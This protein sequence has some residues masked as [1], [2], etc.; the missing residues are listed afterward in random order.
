MQESS[1]ADRK[2]GE[3]RLTRGKQPRLLTGSRGAVLISTHPMGTSNDLGQGAGHHGVGETT[4]TPTLPPGA[5]PHGASYRETPSPVWAGSDVRG[6][7]GRT[8]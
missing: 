8:G 3:K 5:V 4:V 6:R 1:H 2:T 7:R